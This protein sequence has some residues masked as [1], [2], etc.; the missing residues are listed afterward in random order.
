MRKGEER[1]GRCHRRVEPG[2]EHTHGFSNL[3]A[4]LGSTA[5][6]DTLR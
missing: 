3:E 6:Q 5:S 2:L 4:F 1:V